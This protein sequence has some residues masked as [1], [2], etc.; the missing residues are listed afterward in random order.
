MENINNPI[1]RTAW[2]CPFFGC[3]KYWLTKRT[4]LKHIKT[5]FYN[6]VNK[7]CFSC[8]I[9][10]WDCEYIPDINVNLTI[11]VSESLSPKIESLR[12]KNGSIIGEFCTNVSFDRFTKQ[13]SKSIVCRT[14]CPYFKQKN[15]VK[16]EKRI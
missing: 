6:P 14:N 15:E 9:D 10:N 12:D 5:C 3:K 4:T 1:E 8:D 2:K 13:H 16:N 11:G 7:T